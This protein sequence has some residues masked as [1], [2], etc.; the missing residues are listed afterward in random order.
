MVDA[1][2]RRNLPKRPL[3]ILLLAGLLA[4]WAAPAGAQIFHR[5]RCSRPN[6]PEEA[7]RLEV[8]RMTLTEGPMAYDRDERDV[9]EIRERIQA[10][11]AADSA[12]PSLWLA[13]AEA[14]AG[15]GDL[16]A[17]MGAATRA[18]ES[19]GDSV[20]VQ[21]ALAAARM[22]MTGGELEGATQYFSALDRMTRANAPRFLADILPILSQDEL[23]WWRSIDDETRRG[24]VRDY[25]EH[26]AALA[27]ISAEERL[28]EHMRRAATAARLFAP[29]GTGSGATGNADVLRQPELRALPYDDRGLVYVRR[30]PPQQELR[31]SSDIFS[32]LPATTWLYAG[33]EGEVDA[34]HFARGIN[35]GSGFRLVTA[36]SCDTRYFGSGMGNGQIPMTEDWV[37]TTAAA[38]EE[39]T[40]AAVSCFSGDAFSRRANARLNAITLRRQAMHALA[41]ESPREP[42]DTPM[43]AYF[44]FFMFRGPDGMTEVVTPVVVPV[45]AGIR[46]TIDVRV[47]FADRGGGVVRRESTSSTTRTDVQQSIV[48][49]GEG[50]GVAYA[51]TL[52]QPADSATFRII[53][54]D[55]ANAQRGG[56]WGGGMRIR[57]FAGTGLR[58]SDIVVSSSGPGTWTRGSTRLFLLPARSFQPGTAAAVF[59]EL[60]NLEP[61]TTYRTELMLQPED[62]SVG[63]RVWRAITGS[64][65]VRISFDSEVPADAGDVLTELRSL[66]LPLEEGRY[67]LFV[68]VT[69]ARGESAEAR[70]SVVIGSDAAMPSGSP[71]T[72]AT[73]PTD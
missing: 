10:E 46:Q 30:G 36:P 16:T 1:Q 5:T 65:E 4:A 13:L 31:V 32:G 27:G 29:P 23:D 53:V 48:S 39:A 15:L 51:G 8:E 12:D 42:F 21:R 41:S 63:E 52:V 66:A 73:D 54:R 34:F 71:A 26:R 9:R 69:N 37:L 49:A 35:S 50:W 3:Q 14:E 56:M 18:L 2:P 44:D 22:R 45:E 24:W 40:R 57:S 7:F 28:V 19:G 62:E 61:G 60:Y 64:G 6:C 72:P 59:Y 17:S 68:R 67:S 70:R 38:S 25:W 43:P 33:V 20:L 47:T 55:A 11:L 58:M